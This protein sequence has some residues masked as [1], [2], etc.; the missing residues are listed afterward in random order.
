[1]VQWPR[2]DRAEVANIGAY[3]CI[4]L[5]GSFQGSEVFLVD[6]NWLRKY[7]EMKPAHN[8]E[9]YV[10]V[11]LLGHVKGEI[12][13]AYHL[14]PMATRTNSGINVKIWV[15]R[16]MSVRSGEGR[17]H[18][19]AFTNDQGQILKSDDIEEG[20]FELIQQVQ[21]LHPSLIPSEVNV[22]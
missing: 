8:G 2:K 1:M 18:G 17:F 7:V 4:A 9:L 5:C 16:L 10:V 15:E 22:L 21:S 12:G 19:P 14:T 6:L 11:P 3:A 20:V 13:T